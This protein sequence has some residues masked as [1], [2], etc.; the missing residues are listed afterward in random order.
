MQRP[1]RLFAPL[2]MV[3][4]YGVSEGAGDHGRLADV[5]QSWLGIE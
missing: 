3:I 5:L 2:G 1:I 4:F